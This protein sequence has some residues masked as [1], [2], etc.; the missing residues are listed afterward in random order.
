MPNAIAMPKDLGLSIK[1]KENNN[2]NKHEIK[3]VVKKAYYYYK[4][5]DT[6]LRVNV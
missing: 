5:A 3:N 2:N 1:L 6:T 4:H